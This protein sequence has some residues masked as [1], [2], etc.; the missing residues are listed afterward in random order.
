MVDFRLLN[1][2]PKVTLL[3]RVDNSAAL[4]APG[5]K[6]EFTNMKDAMEFASHKGMEINISHVFGTSMGRE[7]QKAKG[8]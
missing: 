3:E 5:L 1:G 8:T 7:I 2:A 6:E 4:V